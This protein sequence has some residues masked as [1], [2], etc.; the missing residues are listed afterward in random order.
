MQQQDADLERE[1]QWVREKLDE[2]EAKGSAEV[3]EELRLQ[4]E[5]GIECGCCFSVYPFVR[6]LYLVILTHFLTPDT[7]DKLVQ[8]PEAHLF[9]TTCMMSYVETK[10]GEHDARIVCMDQSGCKLPFPDLELRRC[11]TPKLFEL[12]ER[13][14]QRK[15]TCPNC[16]TLSCYICRKVIVGYDH[17]SRVSGCANTIVHPSPPPSPLTYTYLRSAAAPLCRETRS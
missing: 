4:E 17:F 12:Y 16:A 7:Q 6:A 11:L 1:M 2:E 10:L 9:C 3:E 13:V 15:M 14:K 5:D 8:C